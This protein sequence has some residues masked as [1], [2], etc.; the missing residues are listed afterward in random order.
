M[1]KHES[2]FNS[3]QVSQTQDLLFCTELQQNRILILVLRRAQYLDKF[4]SHM[5]CFGCHKH[6]SCIFTDLKVRFKLN[7]RKTK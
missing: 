5:Q 6:K 1:R 4:L 2:L 7:F 3:P